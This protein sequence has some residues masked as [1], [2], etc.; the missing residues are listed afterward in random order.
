[1]N[2]M[3]WISLVE[4]KK[5]KLFKSW[6]PK[7]C[8]QKY[9]IRWECIVSIGIV[10][11]HTLRAFV[12]GGVLCFLEAMFFVSVTRNQ[13][14]FKWRETFA[15]AFRT[16]ALLQLA[17]KKRLSFQTDKK[18]LLTQLLWWLFAQQLSTLDWESWNV[19]CKQLLSRRHYPIVCGMRTL[20][21]KR[22][23]QIVSAKSVKLFAFIQRKRL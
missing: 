5:K 1:M 9:S 23:Q 16:L 3:H 19:L 10:P 17:T 6:L 8:S 12:G 13:L 7:F 11:L 2:P 15:S 14:K 4:S 20:N 18:Q 21:E 22:K